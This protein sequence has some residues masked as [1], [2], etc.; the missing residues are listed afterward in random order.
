[1]EVQVEVGNRVVGVD[2]EE[3]GYDDVGVAAGVCT[4]LHKFDNL[5]KIIFNE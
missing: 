2:G 5:L 1:M 3:E 4:D